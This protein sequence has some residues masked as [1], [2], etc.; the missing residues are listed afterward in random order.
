MIANSVGILDNRYRGE[1]IA[2]LIKFDPKAPN[3]EL[4]AKLVQVVVHTTTHMEV[5]EVKELSTTKRGCG[6]FGSTNK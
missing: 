4:P 3:L 5:E 1:P 2:A 6:G